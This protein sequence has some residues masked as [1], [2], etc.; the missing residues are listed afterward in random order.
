[1]RKNSKI[2]YDNIRDRIKNIKYVKG[3]TSE[4]KEVPETFHSH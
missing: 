4:K 1:M 2:T 3:K